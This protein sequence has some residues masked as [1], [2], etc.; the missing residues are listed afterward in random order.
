MVSVGTIENGMVPEKVTPVPVLGRA[1]TW[2]MLG[3]TSRWWALT[4]THSGFGLLGTT[5]GLAPLAAALEDS[6]RLA[7]PLEGGGDGCV[8]IAMLGTRCSSVVI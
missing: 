5:T 6:W 3:F 2:T 8:L 1:C 4:G 7:G